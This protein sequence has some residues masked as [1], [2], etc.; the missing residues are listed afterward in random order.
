MAE[1]AAGERADGASIQSMPDIANAACGSSRAN[2]VLTLHL[3]P[4]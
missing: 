1:V 3:A 4:D 2:G